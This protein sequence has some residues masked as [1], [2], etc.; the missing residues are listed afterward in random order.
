MQEEILVLHDVCA[1][2][3]GK[4][5]LKN[6]SFS[7]RRGELVSII[8][9]NGAGKSTILKNII[10]QL[11]PL[12]G[13]V[14]LA[15][16]NLGAYRPAELAR[17]MSVMLT[18]PVRPEL[19]SCRD[20]VASGRYPFTGQLGLLRMEDEEF[21]ERALAMVRAEA[22]ADRQFSLVSDGQRQ[23]IMLARA[24]CQN[25]RILV[26]DEPTSYLD[27]RWRLELLSLLRELAASG[28]AVIM[29]VHE[30][31]F[32]EKVSDRILCVGSES[33]RMC[34]PDE[35]ARDGGIHELYGLLPQS[36]DS[37]LGI[38]E[39]PPVGGKP[40]VFV[41]SAC[42]TGI[43]VYRML[44]RKRTAFAAGILFTND[45][46]YR[47]ARMLAAQIITAPPFEPIADDVLAAAKKCMDGC[48]KVIDTGIQIA[49]G[50][51]RMEELL[52]YAGEKL[53]RNPL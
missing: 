4:P 11:S 27:I 42:G 43:P 7:V 39:L 15:G 36:F 14:V 40:Q 25:P 8:G 20:V 6:I 44:R 23:R 30:I 38:S 34:S 41:I 10:R 53:C 19:M 22:F 46:D 51:R 24:L 2:Y 17:S 9:P 33:C 35:L 1:G 18:Q 50:N 28:V 45:I 5:V 29:A 12:E 26:L 49:S 31:D 13:S 32:A 21:V 3:A 47:V 16:K 48:S 52:A 37:L